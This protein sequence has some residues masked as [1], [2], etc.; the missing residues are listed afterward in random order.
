VYSFGLVMWE[1]LSEQR[2]ERTPEQQRD[3]IVPP[4]RE[5][6]SEALMLE[7]L[8]N[9]LPSYTVDTLF[10]LVTSCTSPTPSERPT[11]EVVLQELAK[12]RE[13]LVHQHAIIQTA[14]S[15]HRQT[16]EHSLDHRFRKS[17]E[18]SRGPSI[19][20]DELGSF[21]VLT[22][23]ARQA[24]ATSKS[25]RHI[26]PQTIVMTGSS[27]VPSSSSSLEMPT[28]EES[29][30]ET[31]PHRI[32]V[33]IMAEKAKAKKSKKIKNKKTKPKEASD[34]T[35]TEADTDHHHHLHHL[36]EK[37]YDTAETKETDHHH[38]HHHHRHEKTSEANNT[39]H[40]N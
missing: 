29:Q 7:A 31:E 37:T 10:S 23:E 36:D 38:H 4:M 14:S 1:V 39:P 11:S 18:L 8:N 17:S 3:G 30:E 2:P 13:M 35:G 24:T 15:I 28:I 34:T 12:L 26:P 33:D 40:S 19:S 32:S 9:N 25:P 6:L 21:Q 16:R 5:G 20:T 27:D 22:A